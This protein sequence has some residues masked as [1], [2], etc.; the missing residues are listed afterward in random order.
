MWSVLFG[1][2]LGLGLSVG[3]RQ[4]A[5]VL[6]ERD[7]QVIAGLLEKQT[8]NSDQRCLSEQSVSFVCLRLLVN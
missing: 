7:E 4:I 5:N 6:L 1:G 3:S 2:S 8:K